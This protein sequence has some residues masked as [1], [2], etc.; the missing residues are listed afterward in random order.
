MPTGHKPICLSTIIC[1]EVIEDKHTNNKTLVSIFSSIG[2]N[3]LPCIHP[4]MFIMA[5]LTDGHGTVPI[6][7]RIQHLATQSYVLELQGEA[8]FDNPMDVCDVVIE[9]RNLPLEREG[10]YAVEVL[11]NDDLLGARRFVVDLI[12]ESDEE[13]EAEEY[14]DDQDA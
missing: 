1:N 13:E 5:S 12:P 14:D 6:T 8:T 7:F 9:V 2:A 4:R 10:A 3:E 11:G